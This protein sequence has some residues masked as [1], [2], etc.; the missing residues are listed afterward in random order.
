MQVLNN[1]VL[2]LVVEVERLP[3]AEVTT[4]D[5][6]KWHKDI[7]KLQEEVNAFPTEFEAPLAM[8]IDSC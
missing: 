2:R 4:L 7:L 1:N 3:A 8:L 6:P 5:L